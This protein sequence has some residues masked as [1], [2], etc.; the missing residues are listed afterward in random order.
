MTLSKNK[1]VFYFSKNPELLFTP[2]YPRSWVQ[3]T[4][5]KNEFHYISHVIS[6]VTGTE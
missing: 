5:M 6:N 2:Q 1:Y 4:K 3:T